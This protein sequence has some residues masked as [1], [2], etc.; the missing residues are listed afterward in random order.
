MNEMR[1]RIAELEDI[2]KQYPRAIPV[3]VVAE[4]LGVDS[5]TVRHMLEETGNAIGTSW[6]RASRRGYAIPTLKFYLWITGGRLGI[7]NTTQ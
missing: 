5:R 1:T 2:A 6:Q 3:D 7:G 4:F